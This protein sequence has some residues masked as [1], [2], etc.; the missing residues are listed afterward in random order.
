MSNNQSIQILRG[1]RQAIYDNR[2]VDLLAGQPLYNTDDN[3]L[4]IGCEKTN[5][6]GDKTNKTI[7]DLPIVVREIKGYA[8]DNNNTIA[9]STIG[10]GRW[11]IGPT[12]T[13]DTADVEFNVS[14][15]GLNIGAYGGGDLTIETNTEDDL[16]LP[17]YSN[18]NI[19]AGPAGIITIKDTATG[20]NKLGKIIITPGDASASSI[21]LQNG[22]SSIR[23]KDTEVEVKRSSGTVFISDSDSTRISRGDTEI[24]INRDAESGTN[25]GEI[26]FF[27]N[28]A[29]I[30]VDDKDLPFIKMTTGGMTV[31]TG[32]TISGYEH[33]FGQTKKI[34]GL[35]DSAMYAANLSEYEGGASSGTKNVRVSSYNSGSLTINVGGQPAS[36]DVIAK[37]ISIAGTPYSIKLATNT[38]GPDANTIYF[39]Y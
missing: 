17:N 6:N 31:G 18:I 36:A 38:N 21:L 7:G 22:A 10:S 19:S 39:V 32:S 23:V 14:K 35:I 29:T 25:R 30:T 11:H 27:P 20:S 1:T 33:R 9:A 24:V 13:S 34:D 4:T 37:Q 3:Y 28:G 12:S 16:D 8:V 5:G 2:T 26:E 15:L